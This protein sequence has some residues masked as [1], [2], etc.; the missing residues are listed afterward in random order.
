MEVLSSGPVMSIVWKKAMYSYYDPF[1]L[2]AQAVPLKG[3][4]GWRRAA[5]STGWTQVISYNSTARGQF[6]IKQQNALL[7]PFCGQEEEAKSLVR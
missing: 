1:I 4:E 5:I 7:S 6:G 2:T 3:E